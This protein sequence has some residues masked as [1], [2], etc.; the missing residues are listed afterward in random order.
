MVHEDRRQRVRRLLTERAG[1]LGLTVEEMFAHDQK[2]LS[3]AGGT[4]E[5]NPRFTKA[6]LAN[7]AESISDFGDLSGPD[8]GCLLPSEADYLS[9]LESLGE[10]IPADVSAHLVNCAYCRAAMGNVSTH[11]LLNQLKGEFADER[12][13]WESPESVE[14]WLASDR[15]KPA[16]VAALV[17]DR[18]DVSNAVVSI[19]NVSN[20]QALG[21]ELSNRIASLLKYHP[22]FYGYDASE[23]AVSEAA[24]I[25]RTL[26]FAALLPATE[27]LHESLVDFGLNQK[28][29]RSA[30]FESGYKRA[31]NAQSSLRK[32]VFGALVAG[33]ALEDS[34]VVV[35]SLY[36][37][38]QGYKG[39]ADGPSENL[40]QALGFVASHLEEKLPLN[41]RQDFLKVPGRG[42]VAPG[43]VQ[44]EWQTVVWA[45][46]YK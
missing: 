33:V 29:I 2:S 19:M 24:L 5:R 37:F 9:K 11:Q 13:S 35:A 16:D 26:E 7:I 3:R 41:R 20:G 14:T 31:L 22:V 44:N 27:A 39:N 10:S 46:K 17:A 38:V 42:I 1:R 45:D 43:V 6:L 32:V 23:L 30:S 8:V 21:E 15:W 4:G 34:A 40:F 18:V 12:L 36:K 25:A 28:L